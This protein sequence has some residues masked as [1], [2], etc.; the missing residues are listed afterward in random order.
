MVINTTRMKVRIVRNKDN[1][2]VVECNDG[3]GWQNVSSVMYDKP[4]DGFRHNISLNDY[5]SAVKL[6]DTFIVKYRD[7]LPNVVFEEEV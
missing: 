6:K 5:D 7:E 1:R 3:G 2:F 4:N